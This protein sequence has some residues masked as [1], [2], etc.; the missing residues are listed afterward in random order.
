M[1]EPGQWEDFLEAVTDKLEENGTSFAAWWPLYGGAGGLKP[2]KWS[3]KGPHGTVWVPKCA[4][5]R[6]KQ[7]WFPAQKL[8]FWILGY[9]L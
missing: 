4:E 5:F 9:F 8:T 1:S 6:R 2:G 3:N 7:L